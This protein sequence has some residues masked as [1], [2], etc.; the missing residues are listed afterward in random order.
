[1]TSSSA[2]DNATII[3]AHD[4]LYDSN[5]LPELGQQE[6]LL[7]QQPI[8]TTAVTATAAEGADIELYPEQQRRQP[9]RLAQIAQQLTKRK[10]KAFIYHWR[11]YLLAGVFIVT[12]SIFMY[13]HRRQFF[14]AL[15]TLS[16]KLASMGYSG[17]ILM[18]VL[19][20][21]S[22]FPPIL[23]YGTYQ[24]LSGFTFGFSVGFPISYFSALTGAVVCFQLSRSFLKARVVRTLSKYP[25]LEA[26]VNTVEKKGFKLFLLIRFSPYPF[27]LLNVFF[28]ATNISLFQFAA[29]T[30]ISLLKIA[31]HVYIG[32][33]LTSFAKHVLGEDDDLSESEQRVMKIRFAA[34]VL[35]SLLALVVMAYLYRVAKAAVAE[36]ASAD[37]EQMSFLNHHDEEEGFLDTV[38]DD[39]EESVHEP[40]APLNSNHAVEEPRDSVSLDAWDAWGDESD[41]DN[42]G[43]DQPVVQPKKKAL[44]GKDD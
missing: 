22:A 34:A 21:S 19:I 14:Q 44:A 38:D 8:A 7:L 28:A 29:G 13:T 9:S 30:A 35:F 16:D 1:M 23:G 18:S 37:E 36:T 31:L 2:I 4:K 32:A 6:S 40:P 27:N 24:T 15:E 12:S 5:D 20:F 41:N 43:N 42:N 26:V 11:W 10:I 25:N 33:N 39:D 3:G 17:Y